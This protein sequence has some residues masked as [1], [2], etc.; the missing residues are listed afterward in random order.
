MLFVSPE[1]KRFFDT[2][3]HSAQ[4]SKLR[5]SKSHRS[6]NWLCVLTKNVI[7]YDQI[8]FEL[9]MMMMWFLVLHNPIV[10][11]HNQFS[12]SNQIQTINAI[13]HNRIKLNHTWICMQIILKCQKLNFSYLQKKKN[14]NDASRWYLTSCLSEVAS[15]RCYEIAKEETPNNNCHIQEYHYILWIGYFFFFCALRLKIILL[16]CT[17]LKDVWMTWFDVRKSANFRCDSI[18][19]SHC[20]AM[21]EWNDMKQKE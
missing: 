7:G 2:H 8:D 16:D 3:T 1:M 5:Q 14:W 18:D 4:S 9:M 15:S 19:K 11:L 17:R 21:M 10:R 6:A 13:S 12:Y 20:L